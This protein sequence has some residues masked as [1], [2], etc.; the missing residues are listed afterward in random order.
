MRLAEGEAPRS[1]GTTRLDGRGAAAAFPRV[2]GAGFGESHEEP[3]ILGFMRIYHHHL[4][5]VQT[6]RRPFQ[7]QRPLRQRQG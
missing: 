3:P 4:P 1:G 7:R 5:L 6:Q 2:I